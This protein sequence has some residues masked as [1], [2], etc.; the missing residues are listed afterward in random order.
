MLAIMAMSTSTDRGLP[1]DVILEILVKLPV[2]S[3]CRF[4]CVSKLWRST[5]SD[6]QFVEAHRVRSNA[7]PKLLVLLPRIE[8]NSRVGGGFH[9]YSHTIGAELYSM[10]YPRDSD[11]PTRTLTYHQLIGNPALA[12]G[13]VSHPV[14]GLYCLDFCDSFT[15]WNPSTR[16]SISIN[17]KTVEAETG[18]ASK[19]N[20]FNCFGFDPVEKKHKV[21][22]VRKKRSTSTRKKI[23]ESR[24]FVLEENSWRTL[25]HYPADPALSPFHDAICADGVIYF[26]SQTSTRRDPLDQILVAFHVGSERFQMVPIPRES[27]ESILIEFAGRATVVDTHE[28]DG[29]SNK[30][31]LWMLEDLERHVW[32]SKTCVIPWEPDYGLEPIVTLQGATPTGELILTPADITESPLFFFFLYHADSNT[33]RRIELQGIREHIY[34]Q[35]PFDTWTK[36]RFH[37]ETLQDV[38]M[39]HQRRS[40][41]VAG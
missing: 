3:L 34:R 35:D 23:I 20:I 8:A 11:G 24:V 30:I 17:V 21:L 31:T 32:R 14:H 12:Q 27:R 38:P 36:V 26:T 2:K 40:R 37:V 7:R 15:I 33:L 19:L 28:L 18:L 6:P 4:R 9:Y 39:E 16:E 22:S 25:D 41:L 13:R 10:D 1:L 5:I 29:Y